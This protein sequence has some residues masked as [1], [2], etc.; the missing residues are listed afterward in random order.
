MF[1]ASFMFHICCIFPV[2]SCHPSR[3][4]THSH[5][6]THTQTHTNKLSSWLYSMVS[7]RAGLILSVF[8]ALTHSH[9]SPASNTHMNTSRHTHFGAA[10]AGKLHPCHWHYLEPWCWICAKLSCL[11]LSEHEN[12]RLSVC[13]CVSMRAR[14]SVFTFRAF[15]HVMVCLHVREYLAWVCLSDVSVLPCMLRCTCMCM[16]LSVY[17][18]YMVMCLRAHQH[19]NQCVCVCAYMCGTQDCVET[20]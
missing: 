7:R 8:K 13:L 2:M 1:G 16:L 10:R 12:Q 9:T 20:W 19:S 5:V 4:H 17:I 6:R 18:M 3:I 15:M 11:G 14:D